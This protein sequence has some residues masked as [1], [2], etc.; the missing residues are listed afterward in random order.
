MHSIL[1]VKPVGKLT[2]K[3]VERIRS[4]IRTALSSRHIPSKIIAID[5]IP[6][7]YLCLSLFSLC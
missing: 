5:R 6:C 3:I 4:G 7:E 1:F 2:P